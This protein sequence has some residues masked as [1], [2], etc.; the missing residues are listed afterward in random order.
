[1]KL[2]G[3][4]ST[5]KTQKASALIQLKFLIPRTPNIVALGWSVGHQ[6]LTTMKK[7]YDDLG[8]R[9]NDLLSYITH[10]LSL[11]GENGNRTISE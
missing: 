3:F 8:M 4:V 10:L 11:E 2:L 7:R 9:F 1:M 6:Y 5:W